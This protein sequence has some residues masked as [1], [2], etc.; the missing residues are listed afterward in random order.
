MPAAAAAA[1]CSLLRRLSLSFPVSVHTLKQQQL[2]ATR[3]PSK[4]SADCCRLLR[5]NGKQLSGSELQL[6]ALKGKKRET[7][8]EEET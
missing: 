5:V 3:Q 2:I 8:N 1:T 4:R 7:R 6:E